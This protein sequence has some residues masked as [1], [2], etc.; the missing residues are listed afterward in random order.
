[1]IPG[2]SISAMTRN[3]PFA[4][5]A[6]ERVGFV[7]LPDQPR[8]SGFCAWR[9][10]TC[11]LLASGQQ[12]GAGLRENFLCPLAPGPVRVPPHVVHPVF[13]TIGDVPAK[14]FEPLRPRHQLRIRFQPET[15]LRAVDRGA[16]GRVAPHVG[17]RQRRAQHGAGELHFAFRVVSRKD[18]PQ[19]IEVASRSAAKIKYRE[20]RLTLEISICPGSYAPLRFETVVLILLR[21]DGV[22]CC[23]RLSAYRHQVRHRVE[24]FPSEPTAVCF[25]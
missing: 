10:F 2:S 18:V 11:R 23:R 1:M 5:G 24:D 13:V 17:Q 20:R 19:I 9:K 21:P 8:P 6:F 25:L 16:S 7:D 3:R 4:L 15:H 12:R 14:E 22:Q